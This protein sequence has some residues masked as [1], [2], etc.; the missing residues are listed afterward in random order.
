MIEQEISAWKCCRYHSIM[1]RLILM[2]TKSKIKKY[3]HSHY[4]SY[5]SLEAVIKGRNNGK[6]H[7]TIFTAYLIEL[8]FTPVDNITDQTDHERRVI[9]LIKKEVFFI[10][11][12]WKRTLVSQN[13]YLFPDR[14]NLNNQLYTFTVNLWQ[15]THLI[16]VPL[17]NQRTRSMS[18]CFWKDNGTQVSLGRRKILILISLLFL[19]I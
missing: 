6:K 10:S 13:L 8:D 1:M 9:L 16:C 11:K 14:K 3:L 19:K 12:R 17:L 7:F 2:R 15:F 4:L 5:Q 18:Y